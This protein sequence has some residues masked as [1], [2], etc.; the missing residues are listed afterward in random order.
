MVYCNLLMNGLQCFTSLETNIVI[1]VNFLHLV[2]LS[3]NM[4][5]IFIYTN[6]LID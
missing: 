6:T 4:F 2:Y 5:Y 3:T 1:K